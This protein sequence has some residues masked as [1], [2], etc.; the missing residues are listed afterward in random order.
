MEHPSS[1][2]RGDARFVMLMMTVETLL[3]HA[4]RSDDVIEHV[5]HLIAQ[6]RASKLPKEER[7]SLAS[8]LAI[9][10]QQSIRKSGMCLAAKL[11][12]RRYLEQTPPEFFGACYAIRN[13]LVHGRGSRPSSEIVWTHVRPLTEF[14][15]D[16]LLHAL[17]E[18]D[19]PKAERV[20]QP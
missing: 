20:P 4:P 2:Q 12:G 13:K 1:S 19:A 15:G 11:E 8:Y 6:T 5:D 9:A 14:V 10:R 16:L 3:K 18:D 17:A 7:D